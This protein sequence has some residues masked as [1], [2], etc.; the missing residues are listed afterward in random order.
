MKKANNNSTYCVNDECSKKE[1]CKR[2]FMHY[3]FDL[4]KEEYWFMLL[5][6]KF[7]KEGG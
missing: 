7:E 3:K 1:T 5:C 4:E 2:N 6:E